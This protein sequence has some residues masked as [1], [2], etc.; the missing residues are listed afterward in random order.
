MN[1]WMNL[2]EGEMPKDGKGNGNCRV[3]MCTRNMTN[4]ID[5]DHNN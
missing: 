3:E 2:F 1:E 4:S 5:H